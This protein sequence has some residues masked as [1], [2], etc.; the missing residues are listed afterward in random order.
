M[1]G[2]A[3]PG[4]ALM[5]FAAALLALAP[6]YA[7][8]QS[9]DNYYRAEIVIVERIV[10]PENVQERMASRVPESADDITGMMKVVGVD[11][12]VQ[13]T[14]N[15]APNGDLRLRSAAQRLENSGRYRVLMTAGWYQ[16][17]PP[18][19][20]GEPLRVA[21]GDWLADAGHREVEGHITI[22]R[23]RYLHVGVN[24]NHWQ[25][26]AASISPVQSDER[27][28]NN[29]AETGDSD[30]FDTPVEGDGSTGSLANGGDINP[31]NAPAALAAKA[32]LLTWIRETR[33]M[34]SEEVHFIDSPTIGVLVFFRRVED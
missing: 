16:S 7:G 21:V 8:A 10:D 4:K 23:Q 25:P 22:D 19:Y 2:Y 15:L 1:P 27:I 33:R 32:E 18:D 6:M 24:L 11:G 9:R 12:S 26:A 13:S 3:L 14:L 29:A 31:D 30:A 5:T 20:D 17:F 28:D 34:R